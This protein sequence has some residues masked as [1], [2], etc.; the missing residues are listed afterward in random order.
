MKLAGDPDR[1][2]STVQIGIT[3]IGILTGIYS[4]NKIAIDLTNVLVSWGV[5]STYASG[6]AQGII[7]VIVTYLTII[8]GSWCRSVSV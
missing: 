4:G 2:L 6:L 3:L 7:V 5:S 8:L 1:F